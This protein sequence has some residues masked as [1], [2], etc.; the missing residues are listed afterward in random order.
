MDRRRAAT[1]I[2][3][4]AMLVMVMASRTSEVRSCMTPEIIGP[5]KAPPHRDMKR[6]ETATAVSRGLMPGSS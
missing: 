2:N 6:A 4:G 1:V 5:R 3:R